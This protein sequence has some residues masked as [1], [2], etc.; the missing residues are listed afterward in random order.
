MG[1]HLGF[2]LKIKIWESPVMLC[3]VL[4]A[5]AIW[6]VERTGSQCVPGQAAVCPESMWGEILGFGVGEPLQGWC[7]TPGSEASGLSPGAR[8]NGFG[9][10]GI[11]EKSDGKH[12][13]PVSPYV[14]PAELQAG[15]ACPKY[16]AHT[17]LLEVVVPSVGIPHPGSEWVVCL[18]AGQGVGRPLR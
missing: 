18:L 2:G 11:L 16:Y 7:E 13:K 1:G 14:T 4:G 5:C 12:S 15:Q 3:K 9:E 10:V 17:A 6:S 8:G